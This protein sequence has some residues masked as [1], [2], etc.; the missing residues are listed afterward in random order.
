MRITNNMLVSNMMNNMYK[1]L[2]R[3]N[4]VNSQFS[5]GKK[6]ALPS[7]DPIGVS[8]SMRF[9]T[10]L[11]KLEQYN[12]N[13]KD[14]RS[15]MET[16]EDSMNQMNEIV[17]RMRELSVNASNETNTIDEL[18]AMG[19]EIDQEY[20]QLIK[21]SNA[22]YA[23]RSVFTGFKTDVPL[24]DKEGNYKL[25]E[26]KEENISQIKGMEIDGNNLDFSTNPI[27]FDLKVGDNQTSLNLNQNYGDLNALK[28]DINVQ[29]G[30]GST[31]VTAE[32]QDVN[33]SKG[34]L[35]LKTAG[36]VDSILID[37]HTSGDLE[38]IGM[39]DGRYPLKSSEV[40]EYNLGVADDIEVNTNGIKIFGKAEFDSEGRLIDK[41]NYSE[42]KVNGY[43]IV[44][45]ADGKRAN[46]QYADKSYL[47]AVVDEFRTALKEGDYDTVRKTTER[48]DGIQENL[49]Q[50]QAEIG[51]KVKRLELTESRMG[52]E[53]IN[54]TKLLSTNE[55]VDM[56]DTYTQL[57]IEENVYNSSLA[58][59]AKII[60]PTLLDFLR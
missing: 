3:L 22:T 58:A 1:N 26:Y 35:V 24:L 54:F 31:G 48:L 50:N 15:W 57:K 36:G 39:S 23:G 4:K 52:D 51:A 41:A 30:A 38:S 12:R 29:L 43:E 25:T 34:K 13:L 2:G 56:M 27:Q 20:D 16:T 7:D 21:T 8:K 14:A 33:A 45:D 11:G 28:N 37:N 18:R 32:I 59:G 19:A 17:K 9:H 5:S 42:S 53:K 46:K 10:D 55:D 40:S 44:E 60:Q 47:M 49:L 6:F